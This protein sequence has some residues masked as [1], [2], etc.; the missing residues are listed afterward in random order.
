MKHTLI[1]LIP[2]SFLLTFCSQSYNANSNSNTNIDKKIKPVDVVTNLNR[3][4]GITFLDAETMLITERNGSLQ[5]VKNSTKKEINLPIDI[6][7]RG[8]GGLLD[9]E[10]SPDYL[11][12]GYIYMTYSKRVNSTKSTT[13]LVRFKLDENQKIKDFKE[14]FEALPY[15]ERGFH[16]GSRIAFDEAN[17]VFI[18]V[19]D[20]YSYSTASQIADLEKS[21]PQNLSTHLGKVIRLNL[22]GSVPKDNPFFK[23]ANALKEIYSY[24]H[25]N[26]QGIFYDKKTKNLYINEHGAQGGDEVNLIKAGKNYGWPIITY[27]KDYNNDPIGEGRKKEGLEQPLHYWDPSIAPSS[28]TIY[29]GKRYAFWKNAMLVSTLKNQTLYTLFWDGNT[30]VKEEES[31]KQEFG[32]IRD[33][34]VSPDDFIY[35]LIDSPSGKVIKLDL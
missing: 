17:H 1:I 32:R 4:W 12:S 10:I 34:A 29:Q 7:A 19:G 16:Y 35:L 23:E 33:V 28:M 31:F 2:L 13:A 14:L 24:G 21:F 25:R 11:E 22:D 3:P 15:Y 20:R 8:Q 5:Y 6:N 26:P 27:G 18:T 30:L 9:I